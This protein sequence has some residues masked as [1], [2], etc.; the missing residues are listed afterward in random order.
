[1]LVFSVTSGKLM[2]SMA[3]ETTLT[4]ASLRDATDQSQEMDS[5]VGGTSMTI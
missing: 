4:F 1:M 5:P 2:D 3:T